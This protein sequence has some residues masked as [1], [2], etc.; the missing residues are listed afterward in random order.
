MSSEPSILDFTTREL[1]YERMISQARVSGDLV[2]GAHHAEMTH[3]MDK[4]THQLVL[5][6]TAAVLTETD[7]G[8]ITTTTTTT[9]RYTAPIRPRWMPK[10]LWRR[11]GWFEVSVP[12]S[13][14]LTVEPRWKYP[15]AQV[16]HPL[17]QPIRHLSPE[18]PVAYWM[19][20]D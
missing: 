13:A 14:A 4:V 11:I 1:R 17:G 3:H 19:A 16:V 20:G 15:H 9:F 7:D 10:M 6:M 2:A 12:R 18:H 8:P 5:A